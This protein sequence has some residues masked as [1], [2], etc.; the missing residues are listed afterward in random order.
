V[1]THL[2]GAASGAVR[3]DESDDE[4]PVPVPMRIRATRAAL[5]MLFAA[6]LVA[7]LGLPSYASDQVDGAP[8]SAPPMIQQYQVPEYDAR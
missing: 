7:T 1:T 4:F 3:D 6:G 5:V 2:G 8:P